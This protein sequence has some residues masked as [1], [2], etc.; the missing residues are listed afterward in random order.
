M[1]A[2]R[3]VIVEAF[4][5][6][7][8][9]VL[10]SEDERWLVLTRHAKDS[11]AIELHKGIWVTCEVSGDGKGVTVVHPCNATSAFSAPGMRRSLRE[12]YAQELSDVLRRTPSIDL[13]RSARDTPVVH[14]AKWQVAELISIGARHV[15]GYDLEAREGRASS[16]LAEFNPATASLRSATGRRYQLVGPPGFDPEGEFVWL[17]SL[18][19]HG[20]AHADVLSVTDDA[21]QAISSTG[22][23]PT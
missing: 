18:S 1:S 3:A 21:W 7:R 23:N 16:L 4:P 20:L 6:S 11:D 17:T 2:V 15:W 8:V 13:M 22:S 19:I 14:L 10:W 5:F 9:A 12:A